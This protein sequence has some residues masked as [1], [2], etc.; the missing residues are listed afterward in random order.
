MDAY[1]D[2][3]APGDLAK[4]RSYYGLPACQESTKC[5]RVVNQKGTTAWYPKGNSGWAEEESLDLDMVS[6]I[7][8]KCKIILVEANSALIGALSKAEDTA[9]KLGAKFVSNSWGGQEFTTEASYDSHFDHPGVA[10]TASS[11]DFGYGV[12]SPVSGRLGGRDRGRRDHAVDE[13]QNPDR[14]EG[15]GPG[16]PGRDRLRL[17]A[18][19]EPAVL[20]AAVQLRLLEP[21]RQRRRGGRRP[22]DRAGRL[23]LL[24][25]VGRGPAQGLA[26]AGRDQ[27]RRARSLRPCTRWPIRAVYR[28]A[29][30]R[31]SPS[32]STRPTCGT[33]RSARTAA[34][35]PTCAPPGPATTARP[36]W[37]CPR[38]VNAFK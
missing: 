15:L 18:P 21:D 8:P 24:P 13:G 37:A 14:G 1:N 10:I 6:A 27:R 12:R 36:G 22:A 25:P 3:H 31:P 30:S 11:G 4:Y 34:A 2:W 29:D 32:T 33:S 9:V 19:G 26:A 28:L 20:A 17:L 5:L 38:G 16:C 23:R 7:C 35:G